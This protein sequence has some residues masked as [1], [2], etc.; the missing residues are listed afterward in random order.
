[1]QPIWIV[2]GTSE[3]VAIASLL[4]AEGLSWIATVTTSR[5]TGRYRELAGRVESI[6]LTQDTAIAWA[7]DR[8]IAAIVD[9]SH[10]FATQI[11]RLATA[12]ARELFIP[13]LRYERPAISLRPETILLDTFGELLHPHYLENRRVLLTT[14]IKTL[15]LFRDWHERSHL[16]ARILPTRSS[17]EAAIAAG[18]PPDRL[19]EQQLPSTRQN[20]LKL[21]RSLDIDTV[22]TKA[23]GKEGGLDIK[24]AVARE[25]G[26]K[27]IAIARPA[28]D[29]PKQTSQFSEVLAFCQQVAN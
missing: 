18:F 4:S 29:Y 24:Q 26:V 17:R 1:M 10:P 14:G 21:W 15:S 28:I 13:Y 25:L 16:F 7:T 22:V 20:E 11:S 23:A 12:T 27:S 8:H 6:V 2:G 3:G 9:A 19:V 5:A